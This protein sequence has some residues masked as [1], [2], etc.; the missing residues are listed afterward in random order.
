MYWFHDSLKTMW[1]SAETRAFLL[2]TIYL[3]VTTCE[4]HLR[5]QENSV[6]EKRQKVQKLS[7]Q[8]LIRQYFSVFQVVIINITTSHRVRTQITNSPTCDRN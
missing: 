4:T 5:F 7:A 6:I 8:E 3:S 1:I 2:A